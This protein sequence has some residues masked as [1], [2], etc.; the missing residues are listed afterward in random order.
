MAGEHAFEVRAIDEAGNRD[1]SPA[2]HEWTITAPDTTIDAAPEDPTESA[3]ATFE[4]SADRAGATFECSLDNAADVHRVRLAEGVHGLADGEHHFRVRARDAT[5]VDQTPAEHTWEIGDIPATVTI[6]SA[7]EPTTEERG[8]SFT[9]TADE[10]GTAFECALDGGQFAPCASPKTYSLLAVGE[11]TFRVRAQS[12]APVFDPPVA[13]HTWTI[14]ALPPCT[15]PPATLAA[16][17][18][19]WIDQ[20]G[21]D[22]N[23]G[24]DS[25][26]KL[27]SKGPANNVRALV[28]FANPALAHGCVVTDA[29]LRLNA[30]SAVGGRTLQALRVTGDWS[31]GA[32]TWNN[33]P[34]TT[35]TPATVASD[36][37][38]REWNVT[39]QV[40]AMYGSGVNRGFL[41][42][43]A[44]ENDDA[45]QQFDSRE[46]G[47]NPPQLVLTFGAPDF[48]APQTTIDSGPTG[49]TTSTSASFT[50]SS[51]EAGSTFECSL[52]GRP[53]PP[54]AS[55]REYTSLA[56]GEHEV[57]VRA[58]DPSG[59]ADDSPASRQWT[60]VPDTTAPE[61]T[62]DSG[63]TGSTTS[64]TATFE[65][66]S[67][68]SGSTFR[69]SLDGA[70]FAACT[71]PRQ[72]TGLGVGSHE[73]RVQA[74]DAA[75][76]TDETPAV[77]TWTVAPACTTAT[78][79]ADRDSWVLQ[80]ASG[81]NFGTDSILKVDSKSGSSN[82]RALVRFNLPTVPAGCQVTQVKL[83]LYASSYK[84]G[85]TLQ[86]FRLN[87]T[88]AENTV[89][90]GNQP[91]T[92][93][94]AATQ[95][96]RSSAGYVE[97]TVTS[98]VQSMYSG[99]NHGFLI[100]DASENGGGNEQG[101][102]SREKA[103]DNPPQ[104]VV[105]FG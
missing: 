80:S 87:G 18:D 89:T 83:R 47:S 52:D 28:R 75:G 16:D 98:Q 7:P 6:D 57:K 44:A 82:A 53:S 104:L 59:N 12:A 105:T 62:I 46:A 36:P 30:K 9:F 58:I 38:Y 14:E 20:A 8:A 69:C 60:V 4:F 100:R 93:G 51:D 24:A 5:G 37:G 49:S 43:D 95:P 63:P 101:F 1:G 3:N 92:T 39:S 50:F 97:W 22:V 99:S 19:S 15:T 21:P 91:T 78:V 86:A 23:K 68:E 77:R 10:P 31:E 11:H 25:V 35:G 74:T 26:L 88:W 65:F 94:S 2:R 73:V 34:A 81:S 41:I 55:P 64:T 32:V 56:L 27:L 76:N 17:A 72:Y 13:T 40:R 103:P 33:Q 48:T 42:R 54:A 90:W 96:S 61:T 29:K 70:A 45:E 79:G 85:R 67:S 84:S 66:S 102:H 71:S